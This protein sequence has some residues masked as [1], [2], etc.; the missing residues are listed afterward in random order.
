M[1]DKNH[2]AFSRLYQEQLAFLETFPAARNEL[3]DFHYKDRL[4]DYL[5]AIDGFSGRKLF[6]TAKSGNEAASLIRRSLLLSDVVLFSVDS[7]I[8]SPKLAL[9]PISDD[10]SSPVLGLSSV[11]DPKGRQA[12]AP[13][14]VFM[15]GALVSMLAAEE[16]GER[17]ELLGASWSGQDAK[18][19]ERTMFVRL[20]E[21]LKSLLLVRKPQTQI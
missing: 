8:G 6:I 13:A 14:A 15:T 17:T 12:V 20:A 3:L 16:K 19:W 9:L 21:E 5:T 2:D 1:P 10:V 4:D 18:N 7:F 11:I